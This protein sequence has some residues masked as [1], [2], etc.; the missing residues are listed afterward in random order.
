MK[1]TVSFILSLIMIVMSVAVNVTATDG[2]ALCADY[3]MKTVNNPT[4]ASVGGEWA[5]IGLARSGIDV[6]DRY[7]EKY[8][9]NVL[10][11]VKTKDGV[12]HSRKYT[13]YSRVVIALTAIGKNPE[14]VA[15]YNLVIPLLD[16]EKTIW[17]G[18]NGPIWA[19]IA[20]DSGNYA[21]SDIRDKYIERILKCEKENGGWAI[22]EKQADADAD[23]TAMAL[24][25]LSKYTDRVDVKTAT[26]R[27]IKVLSDMQNENGG[28]SAYNIRASEST[29]QVLTALSSLGI[30]YKDERF[31]KNGNTLIDNIYSFA[32]SDGS[33][34]HTSETNLMATEQCFYAL[35]S[36]KRFEENKTSLFDMS[37]VSKSDSDVTALSRKNADVRVPE[38][39]Y[40]GKT[41]SDITGHKN[42]T[43]IEALAARGIINGVSE[44]S[45]TPNGDMTRAEFATITVRALGLPMKNVF[46]F[47]DV[48]SSE[49]FA[50][51]VNTA[52]S[53]GIIN[54]VSETEFD[55]NGRITTEQACVMIERA[56]KL[57]GMENNLD[58]VA[59]RNILS[60]FT[61]YMSVSDWAKSSVAFCI[62]NR[63][64]DGSVIEIKPRDA[65]KRYCI[66]QMLY[67]MLREAWLV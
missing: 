43:E 19:L 46:K 53:Y 5:V 49:W 3:L 63:I 21:T 10:N 44:N 23:I 60:E 15:G 50:A 29:A 16:Y 4:V 9:T 33:F 12:L 20:L 14:N 51:Y 38:V 22:S 34:S 6:D 45:F 41:F 18:I 30:S 42:Q 11:Y 67:N 35:V 17:Q 8:Y 58:E 54:G 56:A 55:P 57:C 25:A 48:N 61:D 36:A 26:E 2:L 7:F 59:V 62:E 47:S 64:S 39:K 31:I 1:K 24:I 66:A 32:K 65:A 52:Y 28:Y 13:E 40:S 37:D 27:G